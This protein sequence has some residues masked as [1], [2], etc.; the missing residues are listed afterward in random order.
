MS[1]LIPIREDDGRQA[2]S[3]R[4]LHAFLGL[5]RDY[6]TWFKSM[7]EYGFTEGEDFTPVRGESPG[8]R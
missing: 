4:D 7:V 3:G 8:D 5:G 2:V 1:A 6:T